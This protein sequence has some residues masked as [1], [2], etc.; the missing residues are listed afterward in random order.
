MT[1]SPIRA[2][3]AGAEPGRNTP[4]SHQVKPSVSG[5]KPTGLLPGAFLFSPAPRQFRTFALYLQSCLSLPGNR[6]RRQPIFSLLKCCRSTAEVDGPSA[7][8]K[9]AKAKPFLDLSFQ[10]RSWSRLQ[11]RAQELSLGFPNRISLTQF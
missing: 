9:R 5:R 3:E 11:M 7:S 8:A 10:Q 6:T 1:Y 2:E 4:V